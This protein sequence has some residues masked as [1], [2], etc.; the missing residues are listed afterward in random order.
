MSGKR[1]CVYH[2]YNGRR[3]NIKS[4]ALTGTPVLLKD[5]TALVL[6]K[7]ALPFPRVLLQPN[8]QHAK[9]ETK[10]FAVHPAQDPPKHA[11]AV[12]AEAGLPGGKAVLPLGKNVERWR[13]QSRVLTLVGLRYLLL[14]VRP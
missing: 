2:C 7:F 13:A 1:F 3:R 11:A 10:T 4:P 12:A 5:Q 9:V 8:A 6:N 14:W